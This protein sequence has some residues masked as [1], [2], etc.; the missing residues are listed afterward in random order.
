MAPTSTSTTNNNNN[1]NNK[2]QNTNNNNNVA[3]SS[4]QSFTFSQKITILFGFTIAFMFGFLS[5]SVS[6]TSSFMSAEHH[7]SNQN[8]QQCSL[9][10]L[11][12]SSSST[13]NNKNLVMMP[14][15]DIPTEEQQENNNN[16]EKSS[17]QHS[18]KKQAGVKNAQIDENVGN[19]IKNDND[20]NKVTL[21]PMNDLEY[22]KPALCPAHRRIQSVLTRFIDIDFIEFVTT[23]CP[24]AS[25]AMVLDIG[26]F[27]GGEIARMARQGFGGII[28]LILGSLI[29][30]AQLQFQLK[31]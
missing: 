31:R 4:S 14:N 28:G 10:S 27:H 26:L 3:S 7:N 8:Q 2:D 24:D 13:N 25:K 20:G 17:D 6:S 1:N 18:L 16:D 21:A 22:R 29:V 9:A 11:T 30:G 12:S 15:D 5:G 23:S 19:N